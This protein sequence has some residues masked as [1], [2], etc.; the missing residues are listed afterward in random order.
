MAETHW[1]KVSRMIQ[2]RHNRVTRR[3]SRPVKRRLSWKTTKERILSGDQ[4]APWDRRARD[5]GVDC[6][7]TIHD[8]NQGDSA[9]IGEILDET[10]SDLEPPKQSA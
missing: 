9:L 5:Q 10:K 3:L 7:G 1:S 6:V 8:E 2:A 4:H